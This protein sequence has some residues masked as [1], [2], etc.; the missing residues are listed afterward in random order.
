ML[1]TVTTPVLNRFI[2]PSWRFNKAEISHVS[3]PSRILIRKKASEPQSEKC[4]KLERVGEASE[5]W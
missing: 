5:C 1:G 3:F 4:V 2:V